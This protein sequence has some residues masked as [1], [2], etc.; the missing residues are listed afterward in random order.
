MAKGLRSSSRKRNKAK[1]RATVFGPLMDARTERLSRKLQKLS[2]KRLSREI[3][4]VDTQG[5]IS[6][7]FP[8]DPGNENEVQI[9]DTKLSND[10][11]TDREPLN[12][13]PRFGITR[14]NTANPAQ[15]KN[16]EEEAVFHSICTTTWKSRES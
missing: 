8:H 7:N 13:K 12:T 4:A 10:M 3:N 16:Q 6:E 14:P 15:K 9:H 5:N 2:S 1:L 11:D